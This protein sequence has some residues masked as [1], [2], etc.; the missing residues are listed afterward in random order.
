MNLIQPVQAIKRI[1]V[2]MV[3]LE[4]AGHQ[5]KGEVVQRFPTEVALSQYTIVSRKIYW[6][7]WVPPKSLLELLLRHIKDPQPEKAE[8]GRIRKHKKKTIQT[9]R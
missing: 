3:D 9:E 8:A 7:E 1:Y 5:G 4:Q 2:N 6:R